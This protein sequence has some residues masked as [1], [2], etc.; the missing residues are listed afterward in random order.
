MRVYEVS[1]AISDASMKDKLLVGCVI[2]VQC[3]VV[4]MCGTLRVRGMGIISKTTASSRISM[5]CRYTPIFSSV[6]WADETNAREQAENEVQSRLAKFNRL[7][8]DGMGEKKGIVEENEIR[9][10]DV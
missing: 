8:E 10:C 4:R 5:R 2:G 7:D 6:I 1:D 3:D 9:W